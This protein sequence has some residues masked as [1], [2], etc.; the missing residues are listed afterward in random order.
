[1][2]CKVF[3]RIS[4]ESLKRPRLPGATKEVCLDN[5]LS[6]FGPNIMVVADNC[7]VPLLKELEKRKLRFVETNLGNSKSFL[8]TLDLALRLDDD[9]L[10]Y[11]VE[12]DYLHSQKAPTLLTE[13][14][15]RADY[16]TVFDHPDKYGPHY[17]GGE[18]RKVYRTPS[19]HWKHTASTTMT[20]AAKVKTLKEDRVVWHKWCGPEFPWPQDHQAFQELWVTRG[21][22]LASSIPGAAVHT[23]LSYSADVGMDTIEPWATDYMIRLVRKNIFSLWDGDADDAM[24][25]ME[26]EGLPPLKHLFLLTQLEEYT[27]KR[28]KGGQS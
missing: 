3:Y 10:V 24:S 17:D 6:I 4:S 7:H 28:K 2:N 12:D 20:F 22:T 16:V 11:F 19:C 21:R 13:G 25:Q 26:R 14:V 18:I 9:T 15:A 5:F 1:M 23:D 8:H 27:R